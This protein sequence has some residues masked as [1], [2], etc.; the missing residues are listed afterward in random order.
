MSHQSRTNRVRTQQSILRRRMLLI[1]WIVLVLATL[2]FADH[3]IRGYYVVDR[4]LDPSW[5]HSGWPFQPQFTP[6]T[7]SLIGVYVL[8]G[9]GIWLTARGRV[10][11]GYWLVSALLLGALVIS[12]HFLGARAETPGVIYHSWE[13]RVLGVAAVA[14]TLAIIATVLA[15]G[16]NAIL[17]GRA[18][19]W[20]PV[21]R[22]TATGAA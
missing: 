10:W 18:A 1:A 5:N 8:L 11:A 9:A 2:H 16:V 20:R 12:V 15:M 3:V 19:G 17:V 4:G 7:G 21:T 22:R 14:N 6:F 13:N